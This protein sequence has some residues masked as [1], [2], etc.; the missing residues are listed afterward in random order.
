M[1]TRYTSLAALLS[2]LLLP[3][4][5]WGQGVTTASMAGRIT[6]R[7]GEPLIGANV[8]AVHEPSGS[9]YGNSTN[10]EGFVRLPNMRV[11]GP[12]TVTISYT[13]YETRTIEG[14]QLRLGQAFS[15]DTEL[16]DSAVD[17]VGVDVVS[18]R[19]AVFDADRTGA[20]TVIGEEQI[21]VLPT[22]S[23]SLGDFTRLTPQ[24]STREGNDGF[25]LS[26]GGMNN[27]YN[28][29]YIDG[30]VNNDVF[31]LA[32][33]GTNGGQTGV[34][35]I[36]VDA[37]ESIQVNLAPFDVRVGGF[38][39]AAVSAI[40]RS[41]TNQV[42]ASAY[43]F[44]RNESFVREEL[45]EAVIEPFS[46]YTTGFRIGGP[47]VK[48]KLF[49][50]VNAELQRE[51]TPL[52]FNFD[53]YTGDSDSQE[54][55]DALR[56]KLAGF[57]YEPGTFE[58]NLRTLNSE[59]VTV[60]FDWNANRDNKLSLRYG[61]V[62][63]D[64][65]EGV[66]SNT[67]TINFLNASESFL[68][69]TSSAAFEW[70]S[71]INSTMSNNLTVGY[72]A[73]RDDRDP[74]GEPFPFVEIQ[75]G[76][77]RIFFGSEPFST[78]NLLNQDI[79]T[80]N[81]NFEIFKGNHQLTFGGNFEYYSIDNLFLAFNYGRYRFSS[82]E[83]FL[84]DRD[85]N[86]FLRTYSLVDNVV[87]DDSDAVASFNSGLAG[88]YVQDKVSVGSDL[89][90]TFGLRGD[91]SFYGDTPGNDDFNDRSARLL[92]SAGYDLRGARIGD[93]IQPRLMLSPRFGFNWNVDGD[94]DT[95][96]RGGAGV[97]TSRVPQVWVGGAYN[98]YGLNAGFQFARPQFNPDINSQLPGDIDPTSGNP[99]GNIDLFSEDFQL[100]QFLKLN[101]AIDRK[102]GWGLIGTVDLM[103]NKTINNVAYQNINVVP[104]N[105]GLDG[106]G[107]NRR[108]F[109]N[110]EVDR[111]YDRVILGYNTSRGYTY[112]VTA[113]LTK[114]FAKG[115]SGTMAYS[116][117]DAYAV[118]DGTSSQNSSQ[119]RGLTSVNGRNFDQPL[120]R[121]D[122]AIGN[123]LIA[124]L[125]YSLPWSNDNA[126][127]S[128]TIFS[129]TA[130]SRPFTYTI[131]NGAD[132][133]NEDSRDRA[134]LYVPLNAAD[135]FIGEL[136]DTDGDE[137]IDAF[138]PNDADNAA[139]Q[140]FIEANDDLSGLRGQYTENNQFFG[141]WFTVMDLR[142][143]QDFG[144]EVGGNRHALQATL[145]IFN[146]TNLI[147]AEWGRREFYFSQTNLVE[148]EGFL[149]EAALTERGFS[150]TDRVP[151]YSY[152]ASII[153]GDEVEPILDDS[154]IQSSRWQMQLGLRYLFN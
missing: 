69:R 91:I 39:G 56:A 64:N 147:N 114:P 138:T 122:F 111:T 80:V 4:L 15:L 58:N 84:E 60:K 99:N 132:L 8:L 92:D 45:D 123:R 48:D 93:F 124:G 36:S 120:T 50:F 108:L 41:G 149:P 142:L 98:N 101:V 100:P 32:G 109:T 105:D 1:K 66:Q 19:T 14:I 137:E 115:L 33:S 86:Q 21:E 2:L 87:G 128:L 62:G 70:S 73:V 148:F 61:Y 110:S 75:D 79:I 83:D 20:E 106:T 43:G 95:Q 72:T 94:D 152:N 144:I 131:G 7:S 57:G 55:I 153:E 97:F 77:G 121:S 140:S 5:S 118:F 53:N 38:A 129:E 17:L 139:L 126:R 35:P 54:D 63:A 81:N 141:P 52:P 133:T 10:L 49:F 65:L 103:F 28:A 27:R 96:V 104:S 26:F 74:T 89:S 29:I 44:Y 76:P 31:G 6:D 116:Y 3:A 9:S 88:L 117:G 12:Y 37:I 125:T 90:L 51:E 154:G 143:V 22:V 113:S 85:A 25:E 18:S 127:T 23:R 82:L 42:Q 46:A 145:D 11:G 146:F 134:P 119:W 102:L 112:N 150:A 78:A 67:R 136:V 40:T 24:S 34:S 151:V 135:I 47:I 71:V 13:G 130:Q 30:A 16:D 59:K 107:D 68:S